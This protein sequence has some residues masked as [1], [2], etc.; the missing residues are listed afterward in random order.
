[1]SALRREI[2][3]QG[4]NFALRKMSDKSIKTNKQDWNFNVVLFSF[5]SWAKCYFFLKCSEYLKLETSY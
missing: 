1:M 4:L 3:N 2:A 5:Q